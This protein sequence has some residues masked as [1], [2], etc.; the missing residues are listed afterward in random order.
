MFIFKIAALF[1]MMANVVGWSTHWE[2]A[3]DFEPF[4]LTESDDDSYEGGA[5]NSAEGGTTTYEEHCRREGKDL[6]ARAGDGTLMRNNILAIDQLIHWF[7][8]ARQYEIDRKYVQLTNAIRNEWKGKTFT[9]ANLNYFFFFEYI[10]ASIG[11]QSSQDADF[12][13]RVY[14]HI[15]RDLDLGE[16]TKQYSRMKQLRHDIPIYMEA[17]GFNEYWGEV[18]DKITTHMERSELEK[19]QEEL[20]KLK[21]TGKVKQLSHLVVVTDSMM[22]N[23][24]IQKEIKEQFEIS[25]SDKELFWIQNAGLLKHESP[26]QLIKSLPAVTKSVYD[27]AITTGT[28]FLKLI[29]ASV[30]SRVTQDC[31]TLGW[32][33]Y[34]H[35]EILKE[36][37]NPRHDS[38]TTITFFAPYQ[39]AL[40]DLGREIDG[41]EDILCVNTISLLPIE[42]PE[43]IYGEEAQ[44]GYRHAQSFEPN[45]YS[46]IKVR[47]DRMAHTGPDIIT[48]I[49]VTGD[50]E[51]TEKQVEEAMKIAIDQNS[52]GGPPQETI[53]LVSGRMKAIQA[54]LERMR[55][56]I[57]DQGIK[58]P[59]TVITIDPQERPALKSEYDDNPNAHWI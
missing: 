44:Q 26:T 56:Q 47:P 53:I 46:Y 14:R 49:T 5:P 28:R 30:Y 38:S 20:Q 4:Q 23:T 31:G 59:L 58:L 18:W 40:T 25:Y 17:Y 7:L 35:T 27:F 52:R 29:P 50:Q 6:N 41:T 57:T 21:K 32:L 24:K 34:N 1:L 43:Y 55:K 39:V 13:E 54:K 8:T 16:E 2:F 51:E 48:G 9:G 15:Q 37:Q 10:R 45:I 3:A 22:R 19:Q 12:M 11:G 42:S 33:N 36:Y